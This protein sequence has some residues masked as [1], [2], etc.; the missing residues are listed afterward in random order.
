MTDLRRCPSCGADAPRPEARFCEHCGTALPATPA[1]AP[2]AAPADPFGDVAARFRALASHPELARSL[3][4]A[5]PVPELAG[6][7]LPSLLLLLL[8]GAL[9][10]A[11][12]LVVFSFCPPLGFVP[13]GAVAVGVF[14]VGRQVITNARA[15]FVAKPALVVELR[16]RLQAGAEHSPANTRHFV[17]LQ[18]EDGSRR[19]HECYASA[20]AALEPGAMGVA[21]LKGDRLAAFVRLGV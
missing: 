19:E 1:A 10:M 18:L 6:K 14:V 7:T 2:E 5:P 20:V 12:S 17:T 15:P 13:L 11:A 8:L 3:A 16:A 9:G 21:Y 4:E